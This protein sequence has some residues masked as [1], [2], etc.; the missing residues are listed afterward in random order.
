MPYVSKTIKIRTDQEQWLKKHP[1]INFSQW[2]RERLDKHMAA[3][4]H[5]THSPDIPAII[6]AA[7]FEER[8]AS[9]TKDKP[10]TLLD[11]K[12]KTIL[13][14]QLELLEEA[15]MQKIVIVRGY[16]KEK[17]RFPGITYYDN[18][19]FRNNYILASLFCAEPEMGQGFIFLYSDIIFNQ[20][21]LLKLLRDNSDICIVA[22]RMWKEH[23]QDRI[24]NTALEAELVLFDEDGQFVKKI[25]R[26]I[27]PKSA[28][29]EFIGLAKFS[30]KGTELLKNSY[31]TNRELY[32]NRI[33][34]GSPSIN[35]A[36]LVEMLQQLI[37]EGAT[38]NLIPIDRGWLEIDTF[39]DYRQ[40][41][42]EI[43]G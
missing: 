34:H 20:G 23:Y 27:N 2:V 7:G 14:R 22:D 40:A 18:P 15:G 17:I 13:E 26:D 21:I 38:V 24:E 9:L 36:S 19:D 4:G 35:K 12:G 39:E 42:A 32:A 31:H 43:E 8:L 29:G 1:G 10:K 41:W 5:L 33:F 16:L 28:C 3:Q 25:G 37:D 6:I 11:I 30:S